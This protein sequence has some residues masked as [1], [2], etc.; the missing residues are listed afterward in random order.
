MATS[1]L[2]EAEKK[3]K[4]EDTPQFNHP[5]SFT[6][7][8]PLFVAPMQG[9]KHIIFDNTGT[10]KVAS[11]FSLNL[12]AISEDIANRLKVDDLLAALANLELKEPTI[13]FL[14]DPEDSS[15]LIKRAKWQRKY[16]HAHN[17]QKWW[18]KNTQKIYNF[19]MQHSTPEMKFTLLTMDSWEKTSTTQDGIMLLK[20]IRDICHKK[21][22]STDATAILD[23]VQMDK[24][25]SFSTSCQP[26]PC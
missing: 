24:E 13:T 22:S 9:L 23:L 26:S 20:A 17:Q 18:D 1:Q 11:T 19:V 8:R 3:P 14:D 6:L 7:T 16:N 4:V 21:D 12:E 15:N 25:I 2:V 10:A 5:R